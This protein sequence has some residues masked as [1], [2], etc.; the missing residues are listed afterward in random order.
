MQLVDKFVVIPAQSFVVQ[1]SSDRAGLTQ[2]ELGERR[3]ALEWFLEDNGYR[4]DECI[5]HFTGDDGVT[6]TEKSYCVEVHH[7]DEARQVANHS[8]RYEQECVL[9]INQLAQAYLVSPQQKSFTAEHIGKW[10]EVTE[11]ASGSFSDFTVF[12][13]GDTKRYFVVK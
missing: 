3:A 13:S 11:E 5:G 6:V 12:N 9:I 7:A 1:L 8:A 4:Y 10:Q 2:W